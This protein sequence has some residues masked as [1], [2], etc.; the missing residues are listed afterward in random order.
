MENESGRSDSVAVTQ[1]ARRLRLSAVVMMRNEGDIIRPFLRQCAEFFDEV[2]IADVRATD[3]TGAAMRSFQ[4]PRLQLHVYEVGRQERYQGALMN[5][6]SRQAF[7]RGTDWVFCLDGDEFI[8]AESRAEL[9]QA[10]TDLGA[11]VMMMPWINLVPTRF[12]HFSSF[13]MGQVFHWSGRVSAFSKIAISSL[14]AANNPDYSIQEGNHA[15]CPVFGGPEVH[16]QPGLPLLHLSVRSLDRL[17]YKIG[18]G[19]RLVRAKHNRTPGEGNHADSLDELLTK[20]AIATP[21]LRFLAATYGRQVEKT[22]ALDPE[23]LGWPA[24]RLPAF[25][26]EV[27]P[28]ED[29]RGMVSLSETLSADAALTWDRSEFIKGSRVGALIEGEHIRIA[30]QA[31]TGA[32]ISRTTQF[33]ALPPAIIPDRFDEDWLTDVVTTSCTPIQAWAFSAWTE[34]VP[35][36]YSLFTLLRPRRY[37]ELGVHNGMSFFAACQIAEKLGVPAECVAVD[38]WVGDVHASFHDSSVF[39]NFRAYIAEHYPSQYFLQAYFA[40][41]LNC[42]DEGSVD[43]LHIDG[44]H[45]YEAVKDDFETWLPKM[46]EAGVIIFHDT[47]E[48]ARGFGVWRLWE[49]LKQRYPAFEFSHQHGLGIIFV[50][51]E[52]HPFAALL[53]RLA[54]SRHDATLAQTYFEAIGTLLREQRSLT[55]LVEIERERIAAPAGPPAVLVPSDLTLQYADL[56]LRHDAVLNSTTWRLTAPLRAVLTKL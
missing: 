45:T 12:G 43:L 51:R 33:A 38:S 27:Q 1:G 32:G 34:L 47:N 13:D 20:G 8:G 19:L 30:P 37:V 21:E 53:R 3:G 24:R 2:F 46:S 39:D 28:G 22:E 41:A 49:E 6:L 52:P 14:Y 48:F 17:K 18:L 10:L 5:L 50:G 16:G 35:V 31:V 36:M 26:Q 29:A 42:F 54:E 55:A 9:E 40:A 25:L 56:Q 23:L 7:A 44:L 15:V 4:D 11:D